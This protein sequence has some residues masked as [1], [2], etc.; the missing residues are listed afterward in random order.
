MPGSVE[1]EAKTTE[2]EH[3]EKE[4]QN[5][6]SFPGELFHG[7]K[8][9][10]VLQALQSRDTLAVPGDHE[11]AALHAEHVP[12]II[13]ETELNAM[14]TRVHSEPLIRLSFLHVG[15]ETKSAVP[16]LRSI[17]CIAAYHGQYRSVEPKG[18]MYVS[19]GYG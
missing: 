7:C 5:H 2:G 12:W 16:G 3:Q 4:I 8:S 6:P 9:A 13:C 14:T 15:Q 1:C 11:S 17:R 18:A 19:N 10:Q